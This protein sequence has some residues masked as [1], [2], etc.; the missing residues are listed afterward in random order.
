M[1][2]RTKMVTILRTLT[3][4]LYDNHITGV[5]DNV[6]PIRKFGREN[7][8]CRPGLACTGPGAIVK[9]GKRIEPDPI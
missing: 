6:C 9:S 4:K 1:M 8:N 7:K 3:P 5:V 2:K